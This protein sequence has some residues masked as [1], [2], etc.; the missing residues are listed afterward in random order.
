MV[1]KEFIKQNDVDYTKNLV[2]EQELVELEKII[3][4]TFGSQLKDYILSYGYLGFEENQVCV[5]DA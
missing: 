1:Y 2:N 5:L 4:L 3:E